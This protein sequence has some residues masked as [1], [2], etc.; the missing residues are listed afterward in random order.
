MSDEYY[1]HG[2]KMNESRQIE[3]KD[4]FDDLKVMSLKDPFCT[5]EVVHNEHS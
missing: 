2:S 5:L 1:I 3:N 4:K